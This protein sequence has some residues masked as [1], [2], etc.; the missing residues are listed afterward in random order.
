MVVIDPLGSE[1]ES[2]HLVAIES[3]TFA[4]MNLGSPDVLGRIGRDPSVDV[5]ESVEAADR[6]QPSIDRRRSETTQ[7]EVVSVQLHVGASGLEHLEPH[8]AGP[9]EVAPEILAIGLKRP[10][11]VASQ[12]CRC[13]HLRFI[14]RLR[15]DEPHGELNALVCH[16]VLPTRLGGHLSTPLHCS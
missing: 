2:G 8:R 15:P 12:K 13:S 11:A 9:S 4:R 5:G 10:A 6:R 1:Q 16:G 7:F 3:T 14:T